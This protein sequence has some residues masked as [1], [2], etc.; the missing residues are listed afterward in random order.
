MTDT[1]E[2][3]VPIATPALVRAVVAEA[4]DKRP[5]ARV[6][7]LSAQPRWHYPTELDVNGRSVTVVPCV[8]SLAVRQA[9]VEHP[10][11]ALLAVLTDRPEAD[12]GSGLLAHFAGERVLPLDRWLAVRARFGASRH[13]SRLGEW[14]AAAL[15][16]AEPPVGW[17]PVPSGYLD[18]DT[19]MGHLADALLGLGAADLDESGL[20]Q[21]TLRDDAAARWRSLTADVRSGLTQWLVERAGP[22]VRVISAASDAGY[23]PD[24]VPLGLLAELAATD[25][26]ESVGVR[27]RLE[28]FIGDQPL[29]RELASRWGAASVGVVQRLLLT[30]Q[31]Q[32]LLSRAE[33]LVST[34]GAASLAGASTLLPRGL[35]GR[36]QTLAAAM[37]RALR[38]ASKAGEVE[39]ALSQ[40]H[41]HALA[42]SGDSRVRAADMGV[43]LL[44]WLL[45]EPQRPDTLNDLAHVYLSDRGWVDRARG[46]VWGTETDARVAASYGRLLDRVRAVRDQD[47]L[48]FARRLATATSAGDVGSS[49]V[50]EQVLDRVVAPLARQQPVLLVLLDGMS[51]A[52]AVELAEDLQRRGWV[53]HIRPGEGRVPVLAALPTVTH[54]SRTSLFSGKLADGAAPDERRAFPVHPGLAAVSGSG[55]PPALFHKAGLEGA[56]GWAIAEDL[57]TAVARTGPRVVGVVLNAV[58]EE[59]D[60]GDP[61]RRRWGVDDV[62]HLAPL[63]VAARDAGRL[64]ILLSDHGHVVERGTELRPSSGLP[65]RWRPADEPPAADEVLLVGPRVV[66]PEGQIVAAATDGIRYAAKH[67]GYHGGATPAEVVI[68]FLLFSPSLAVELEGW[69]TAPPQQPSWWLGPSVVSSAVPAIRAP[70][71]APVQPSLFDPVTPTPT[72]SGTVDELLSSEILATQRRRAPRARVDDTRLQAV[73]QLLLDH[74]G[75]AASAQVAQAAQLPLSRLAGFLSAMVKL[76]NIEGYPVLQYDEDVVRLDERLLRTQFGLTA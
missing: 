71:P 25:E 11:P 57:A 24:V 27:T 13:D 22:M 36:L 66:R 64:L 45:S 75:T 34:L 35:D 8:S 65:A 47:D 21:W 9:L 59:L 3:I 76:I 14:A 2:E 74:G 49:I 37:D 40:V 72:A 63:A 55:L 73:I 38:D 52:V 56:E 69:E 31:D 42:A 6:V 20:L 17:P 5:E 29:S 70:R 67:A 12:L 44:R 39:S 41:E 18:R 30:G 61:G 68:P 58:D 15:L 7:A 53:E 32:P 43:R 19:A 54:I 23:T 50:V 60:K 4:L 33:V 46:S 10:R 62:R 16:E 1:L 48:A 28:R 26:A 51:A